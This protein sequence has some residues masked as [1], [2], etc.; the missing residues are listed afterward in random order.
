[1]ATATITF[2]LNDADDRVRHLQCIK[3]QDL[4]FAIEDFRNSRKEIEHILDSNS[5]T[6]S[7]N[8]GVETC[9]NVFWNALEDRG[10]NLDELCI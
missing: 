5:S 3:V 1:M 2:D 8:D 10:I 9:Y 6:L 7:L 4:I